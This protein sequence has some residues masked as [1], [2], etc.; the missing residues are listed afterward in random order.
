MNSLGIYEKA[1]PKTKSWVDCLQLVKKLGFNFL[2]FSI[3]ESDERLARLNWTKKQ[4]ADLRD[5]IWQTGVRVHTLMLSG[6]RRYPLGSTDPT[7]RKRSLTMLYQAIDLASNIG[8]RNIQLAGYDVYYEAKSIE[9]REYFIENLMKGVAYAASKEVMLDIET[10]DDSFLNSLSKVNYIKTQIH[11]PWL[12]TYPDLGNLTAWPENDVGQELERGV[13][14]IVSVHLKDTKP[15]TKISKG[16]FRD[17]PFGEGTVDFVGCLRTL[18]RLNY[19]GA[20]TIEMWTEKTND[21]ITAV[22]KAK[23]FF[24]GIFA[25]IGIEQEEIHA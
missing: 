6:H 3:D 8:I 9:S 4:Q 15:V 7:I 12:Q 11:S 21:P 16:Q 19:N 18:K 17:V 24:D 20:F 5:A 14:S 22:K 10:M 13:D 2:E 23:A 25:D 1:L